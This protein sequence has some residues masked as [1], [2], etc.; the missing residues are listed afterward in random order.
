[1][2]TAVDTQATTIDRAGALPRLTLPEIANVTLALRW[3]ALATLIALSA[4]TPPRSVLWPTALL[5]GTAIVYTVALTLYVVRYPDRAQQAAQWAIPCDTVLLMTGTQVT[6]LS[7]EFLILGFPLTVMAGLI[8]GRAAAGA[9]AAGLAVAVNPLTADSLFPHKWVAWGLLGF[10]LVASGQAGAAAYHRLAART[11]FSST[12]NRIRAVIAS[13]TRQAADGAQA[14]LDAAVAHFRA[15]SGALLLLDPQ[16]KRLHLLAASGLNGGPGTL[17]PESREGLAGWMAQ[18]GRAVLVRPGGP[19]AVELERRGIHSSLRVVIPVGG[20]PLGVLTLGRSSPDHAEFTSEDLEDLELIA[21]AVSSALLHVQDEQI[22]ATTLTD[23]AGGHAKVS[24]A[25]TRDPIVLWPALLDLLR[26]LTSTQ[27]AALALERED[28]GNVEIV[29]ARGID[30]AAARALLPGL[31]AA[32]T[33]G[34]IHEMPHPGGGSG[35]ISSRDASAICV[36]LTLGERTIGAAALGPV[37]EETCP[38]PLL[39]AIAA[40]I[41]AAVDATRTA[42][43]VADIGAGE[44]RRRIAREMHDGVAQTLANALLQVD[45]S[46]MTAQ[47][48]PERLGPELKETRALLEQAMREIREFLAELRRTEDGDNRLFQA[49]RALATEGERHHLSVTLIP[50]GDDDRLPPAVRHAVLAIARQALTN[51]HAHAQATAVTVRAEVTDERC[52]VSITDDGIG[53]N[54]NAFRATR[55]AGH[56]LGLASMEERAAL[57]GGRLTIESALSRGT[58]VTV[59]VPLGV[60]HGEW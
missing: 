3:L 52:A 44:E 25:L 8:A 35:T 7:Q 13:S 17:F 10:C 11:R 55:S 24:Y 56:H 4:I 30:G 57:V 5:F 21:H 32:T 49:L 53:F 6:S 23:L 9:V 31:L 26:S 46:A 12:L 50:S 54:V 29:A 58:T 38:R 51:V 28:S 1:V 45:L 59:H 20:R 2:V 33:R 60:T 14:A 34:A 48:A 47:S 18:G 37:T 19:A 39:L 16:T 43:R 36:P 40:H 22:L 15:D 42:H 41:A 27:F